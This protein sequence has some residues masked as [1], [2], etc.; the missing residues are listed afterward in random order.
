MS[1]F[2]TFKS[3]MLKKM[4][5]VW[6]FITQLKDDGSK[7]GSFDMDAWVSNDILGICKVR[8]IKELEDAGAIVYQ[9]GN[10]RIKTEPMIIDK[11]NKD[12]FHKDRNL[13]EVVN[14]PAYPWVSFMNKKVVKNI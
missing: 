5:E 12:R 10:W 7:Y 8:Q 6:G 3:E 14:V 11:N 1:E 4:L 13:G 2:K 9:Y